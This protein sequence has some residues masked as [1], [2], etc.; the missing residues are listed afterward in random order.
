[1]T[2][3]QLRNIVRDLHHISHQLAEIRYAIYG[4]DGRKLEAARD[5]LTAIRVQII[6]ELEGG[7][8]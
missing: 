3:E 5:D 1:M 8:H 7:C 2:Q 6:K 4:A